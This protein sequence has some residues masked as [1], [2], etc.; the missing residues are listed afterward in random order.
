MN[1][2]IQDA[3]KNNDFGLVQRLVLEE[4][5]DLN[6]Q[7]GWGYTP[8]MAAVLWQRNDIVDFLVSSGADI[9]LRCN[10]GATAFDKALQFGNFLMLATLIRNGYDANV[11]QRNPI[12]NG[13]TPL[14]TASRIGN[15]DVVELL[16]RE[17]KI[18]LESQ[19]N[20]GN[21]ALGK[22]A[23]SDK[24]E[25]VARLI[26]A[27]AQV[28]VLNCENQTPLELASPS[29]VSRKLIKKKDCK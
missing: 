20:D 2:N 1:A 9:N 21:T 29:S 11:R 8:L 14:I 10:S 5:A 4:K 19:D 13:E 22:A 7:D 24:H 23:E 26:Q 12:M 27:G 18:S 25:I 3:I 6:E 28:D 15:N 16:L 17:G